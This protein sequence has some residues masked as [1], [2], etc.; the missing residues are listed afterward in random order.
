MPVVER[1]AEVVLLHVP[2]RAVGVVGA[3]PGQHVAF[4]VRVA[5]LH[6]ERR[7]VVAVVD[8]VVQINRGT[9]MVDVKAEVALAVFRHVA[10][11]KFGIDK[12]AVFA[13]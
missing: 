13:N 10:I 6:H 9:R 3:K 1:C 4:Q 7:A 5:E 8:K 12:N 11:G 2:S